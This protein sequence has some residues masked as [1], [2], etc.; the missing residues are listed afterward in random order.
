MMLTK[1]GAFGLLTVLMKKKMKDPLFFSIG[2]C[3][4][5]SYDHKGLGLKKV[6]FFALEGP[7]TRIHQA[8][9]P[10]TQYRGK[11]NSLTFAARIRPL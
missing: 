9:F 2:P 4:S 8:N 6:P 7:V 3:S 5:R 10:S 1:V 11:A